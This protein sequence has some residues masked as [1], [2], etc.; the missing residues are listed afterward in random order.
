MG[1]EFT[2]E[3]NYAH[4]ALDELFAEH[5]E[6]C[7][8]Y[9]LVLRWLR[10]LDAPPG[11]YEQQHALYEIYCC[12]RT[13]SLA[14][15]AAEAT[16]AHKR[17]RDRGLTEPQIDPQLL[18]IANGVPVIF[19][20]TRDVSVLYGPKGHQVIYLASHERPTDNNFDMLHELAEWAIG[21]RESHADVQVL[22]VLLAIE[23]PLVAAVLRA[24]NRQLATLRLIEQHPHLPRWMPV[25]AVLLHGAFS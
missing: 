12:H 20:A 1:E 17:Y 15:L 10:R 11:R 18:A 4:Q 2:D 5:E 13:R 9:N 24:P 23:K 14:D 8:R 22:T 3:T 25:L 19:D 7:P 16:R 6:R 21:D